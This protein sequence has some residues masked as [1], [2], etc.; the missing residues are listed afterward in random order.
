MSSKIT[1]VMMESIYP[2]RGGVHEQVYLIL[3]ELKRMKIDGNIVSYS[4]RSAGEK[5]KKFLWLR[6]NSPFFIRK[7]VKSGGDVLVSETAWPIIPTLTASKIMGNRCIVHLHSVESKQDVGLS[8]GG[9]G[10]ISILERFERFCNV[11]LVPSKIEKELLSNISSSRIEVM[12]N[13]IDVEGF[14][15]Y[16]PVNLMKPSVVFV[17]G[18]GYPPNREAAER[19]IR[20]SDIIRRRGVLVNFYLV[21]PS[22]PPVTPPVYSTGYV[23]STIPYILGSDICI[24]PILR[25]GGVKLKVLEYMASGK[26]IIASK[27][28]VEGID[29]IE[30][31]HAEKDEEFAENIIQIVKGKMEISKFARNKELTIKNHSPENAVNVLLK[32]IKYG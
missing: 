32:T 7:I 5:G 6:Q 16:Q 10:I 27:K 13:V 22:P 1:F 30:Y 23:E 15:K 29:E 26:P 8:I 19:I 14:K 24:A 2:Q 31:I 20:I 11:I 3:R 17:G 21:G 12:Q 25:G 4:T 28:A 9:K 18:M